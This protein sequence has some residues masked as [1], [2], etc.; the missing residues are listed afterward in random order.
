GVDEL[1][2]RYNHRD[3]VVCADNG[4]AGPNQFHLSRQARDLDAI[5]DRDRS[6]RQNDEPTDEITRDILQ[7]KPDTDADRACENRERTEMNTGVLEHDEDADDQDEVAYDL[8]D[9]VLQ[10]P[11]QS[12]VNEEAVKE[13]S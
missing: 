7:P 4:A 5:A 12:A 13:K 1:R 2:V 3:V 11:I 8:R 10:R 6:L 9:G